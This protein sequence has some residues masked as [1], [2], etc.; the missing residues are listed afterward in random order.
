MTRKANKSTICHPLSMADFTSS[1]DT[2]FQKLNKEGVDDLSQRLIPLIIKLDIPEDIS[3][4]DIHILRSFLKRF[5]EIHQNYFVRFKTSILWAAESDNTDIFYINQDTTDHHVDMIFHLKVFDK[6]TLIVNIEICKKTKRCRSISSLQKAMIEEIPA[7]DEQG[8]E[9]SYLASISDF[10]VTS[11]IS[12]VLELEG[13]DSLHVMFIPGWEG[14][15]YHALPL[16]GFSKADAKYRYLAAE[17]TIEFLTLKHSLV[18]P[19]RLDNFAIME[20]LLEIIQLQVDHGDRYTLSKEIYALT[21]LLY[22]YH[23]ITPNEN[24]RDDKNELLMFEII[25]NVDETTRVQVY[26]IEHQSVSS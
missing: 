18:I 9:Y 21:E 6:K 12:D 25:E 3:R 5:R 24:K 26:S 11:G 13:D 22:A 1:V 19:E 15:E 8:D 16:Y 17:K 10:Y 4:E 23:L 7:E 14:M 2:L 20:S